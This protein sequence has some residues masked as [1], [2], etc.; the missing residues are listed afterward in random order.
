M[1]RRQFLGAGLSLTILATQQVTAQPVVVRRPRIAFVFG[2]GGARGFAHI[3]IIKALEEARL[4]ADLIV[5]SS[6]GALAGAFLAAG[7]PAAQL[8]E[9]ALRTR[10]I[11]IV[12][13]QE[14]T[15][16]GLVLGDALQRFVDRHLQNRTIEQLPTPLIIVTTQL[17]TGELATFRRGPTGLAVRASCSIPGVFV[18]PRINEVE[19]VDGGLVSPVPV[20]VARDT[21]ADIVIACDVGSAPLNVVPS[22]IFEQ[23]MH[24]VDIMSR[25]LARL[26]SEQA[27]IAIRPDLGKIPSTD[28]TARS[29]FIEQ[30]Y[31]AGQRFIPVIQEFITRWQRQGST[32]R[33]S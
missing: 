11:D 32:R 16:R 22:G 27:D 1:Q 30:G 31:K 17:R 15:K 13:F 23:V 33:K 21:G 14:G 28:F 4:K 10:D 8:E 29:A 24:S 5:G 19:Y 2:S 25:A 20:K 9:L 26:E 3:G 18:P 6:A 7:Y 12:D